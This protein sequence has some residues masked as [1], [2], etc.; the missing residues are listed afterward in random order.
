MKLLDFLNV[1]SKLIYEATLRM[2]EYKSDHHPNKHLPIAEVLKPLKSLPE[3]KNIKLILLGLT[4]FQKLL[5]SQIISN[6]SKINK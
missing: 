3:T 5:N 4:T 1:F 6:V 2:N